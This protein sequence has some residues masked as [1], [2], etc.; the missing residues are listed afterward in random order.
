MTDQTLDEMWANSETQVSA[1]LFVR[2]MSVAIDSAS[3]STHAALAALMLIGDLVEGAL[4]AGKADEVPFYLTSLPAE[5]RSM[6]MFAMRRR[7]ASIDTSMG[8]RQ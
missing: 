1:L 2:R 3:G 4:H 5:V 6:V 8:G 7:L